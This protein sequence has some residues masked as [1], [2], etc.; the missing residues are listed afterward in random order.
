MTGCASAGDQVKSGTKVTLACALG[1]TRRATAMMHVGRPSPL[2]GPGTKG[3]AE[4]LLGCD[5]CAR[6]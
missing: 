3:D 4:S 1:A 2:N 5:Q 6:G